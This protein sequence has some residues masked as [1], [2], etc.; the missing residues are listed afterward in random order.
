MT[1]ETCALGAEF[2]RSRAEVP[3]KKVGTVI[4]SHHH[5]DHVGGLRAA[6]AAPPRRFSALV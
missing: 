3:G 6:A 5:F 1:I 4:N 2:G